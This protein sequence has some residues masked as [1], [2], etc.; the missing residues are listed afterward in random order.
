[1][2]PEDGRPVTGDDVVDAALADLDERLGGE[3]D[4]VTVV[5]EA[6]RVLQ[7]R[8]TTPTEPDRS[9]QAPPGQAR[10]GPAG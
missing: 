7:Q 9:G 2:T 4:P 8:L 6:H 5:V 3:A 1:M 10:P